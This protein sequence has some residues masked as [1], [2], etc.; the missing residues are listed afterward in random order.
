MI[1]MSLPA[2]RAG[3][4]FGLVLT[5]LWLPLAAGVQA[6]PAPVRLD[7]FGRGTLLFRGGEDDSYVAAPEVKT[8]VEIDV[9]GPIARTTVRQLFDNPG[10]T[11][12]EG[13]YVFPLP[14]RAAVDGLKM[15]IG[16]R[17]IE[18]RIDERQKAKATYEA[19]KREGRKAALLEAE[20]PNIFTTSV[21]NIGPGETVAIEI[22]YQERLRLKD[23]AFHL[24]FPMV[25]GPRFNPAAMRVAAF[26]ANGWAVATGVVPDAGRITPPVAHP[27]AGPINPLVLTVNL[28]A[29]FPVAELTSHHHPIAVSKDGA[30][31]RTITL[32]DGA[33]AADRDF[34]LTWRPVDAGTPVAGL[35]Y[36]DAA[37]ARYVMAMLMPPAA[38]RPAPTQAARELVFVLDVSGSM[39]GESIRQ[40]RQ[41][42]LRALDTLTPRDRFNIIAFS[43]EHRALHATAMPATARAINRARDWI[44]ALEA[45]GGTIMAPALRAAL[46]TAGTD[47][48][49]D[50]DREGHGILR[51]IVFLT[52]GAVG[53][54]QT[55]FELIR[56]HLGRSRLFTVG[57]GSAPN[58]HF[59]RGA[60]RAGRGSFV[61]IGSEQQVAAR[62]DA[63]S[64]QLSQPALTDIAVRFPGLAAEL[65]PELAPDPIPD[66]YAGEPVVFTARLPAGAEQAAISGRNG[67]LDWR[68][69]LPLTGGQAAAGVARLWARE[70]IAQRE[71]DRL[72]AED[73]AA[74][75]ADILD[76][77]LTHGLVSRLTSLVAVDVT[78]SRP[79]GA[80]L[81]TKDLATNLP[82]G[83]EFEKVF[84]P[85]RPTR[86]ADLSRPRPAPVPA[87]LRTEAAAHVAL[88]GT[89]T[90]ALQRILIGLA[91]LVPAL[92]LL[93]AGRRARV[94]KETA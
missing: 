53:N 55:L 77:A 54:E 30:A 9:A 73:A 86:R 10:K 94:T 35:F 56:R 59:M 8:V 67:G 57:I 44:A 52:D 18:G 7:D 91:L 46:A 31:R 51:Q 28:A 26:G 27:D 24:R 14:D 76:L 11:W 13:V 29:G 3:S 32:A 75:D 4:L 83:W 25:V 41:A 58:S 23:G 21:A 63:L 6:Q 22:Q 69:A 37:D 61:H 33:V 79:A 68:V 42:L 20:R 87:S 34:E 90:P 45:G 36:E 5:L 19:A 93:L 81:D 60:A 39:S 15:R 50:R 89:A 62:I 74:I 47:G 17:L 40:A 12:M 43:D 84:G 48:D 80:A 38:L 88:P 66:L 65:A 71:D 49:R 82:H 16:A 70:R 1:A 85:Q 2:L 72:L 64:T 78:P 92:A